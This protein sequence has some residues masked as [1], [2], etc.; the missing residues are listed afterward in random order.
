MWCEGFVEGG[1]NAKMRKKGV[2]EE[3]RNVKAG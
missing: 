1:E 3:G 2:G